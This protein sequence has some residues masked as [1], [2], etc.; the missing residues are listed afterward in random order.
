[1]QFSADR[2]F[3]DADFI[4]KQDLEPSHTDESTKSSLIDSSTIDWLID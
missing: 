1:M 4:L 2:L 3:G